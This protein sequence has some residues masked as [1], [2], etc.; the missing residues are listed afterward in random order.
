MKKMPW[1]EFPHISDKCYLYWIG[2]EGAESIL[3]DGYI[4]VSRQP[5]KRFLAHKNN[6]LR[7]HYYQHRDFKSYLLRA[8]AEF[9]IL[10]VG[11][12]EYCYYLENALRPKKYIGWNTSEGGVLSLPDRK[13]HGLSNDPLVVW[14]YL[15]RSACSRV[16]KKWSGKQ[17]ILE[18]YK[19]AKINMPVIGQ[20][21]IYI[22]KDDYLRPSS[23]I[24]IPRGELYAWR[25]RKYRS[26]SSGKSLTVLEWSEISNIR[27]NT[28]SS[29]L[30]RGWGVD[31]AVGLKIKPP[32]QSRKRESLN[33]PYKLNAVSLLEN[34]LMT[35]HHISV[36]CGFNSTLKRVLKDFNLPKWM[37]S[38]AEITMPWGMFAIR[39]P[40]SVAVDDFYDFI[41]IYDDYFMEDLTIN[42]IAVKR[43]MNHATLKNIIEE[44]ENAKIIG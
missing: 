14:F 24:V 40:R 30:C 31:E 34:T 4:G 38:Y 35:E 32:N 17:G 12:E 36:E 43:R 5:H 33:D 41:E 7:G 3:T 11:E 13:I 10:L 20:D 44:A 9:S 8:D 21:E 16:I 42:A 28:I 6:A 18:F 1:E 2:E 26:E 23:I 39:V 22:V 19:W 29:R 27:P 37:F 25:Y 15:K